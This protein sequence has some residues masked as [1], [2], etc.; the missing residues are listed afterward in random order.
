VSENTIKGYMSGTFDLFHVGHLNILRSARNLCTHLTV[1]VH[2][3]GNWKGKE[4][5]IPFGE[6]LAIVGAIRFVDHVMQSFPE[7]ADAW[8][9]IGYHKLFVGSDYSGSDRFKKYEAYFADKN[10]EIVYLP[11]TAHTSSTKLR[12]LITNALP[13]P[14]ET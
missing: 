11:Y 7:D 9:E 5:F 13:D 2:S 8:A 10:V 3:S 6:R 14:S 4:T 12:Q 1:G